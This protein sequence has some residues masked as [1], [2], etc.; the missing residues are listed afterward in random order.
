MRHPFFDPNFI[1]V[2]RDVETFQK[3]APKVPGSDR[4]MDLALRE[5]RKVARILEQVE[6]VRRAMR[7]AGLLK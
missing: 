2:A 5:H 3:N 4:Q 7:S 6:P 1:R